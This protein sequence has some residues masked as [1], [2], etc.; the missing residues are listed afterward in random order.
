MTAHE[1]GVFVMHIVQERRGKQDEQQ[2]EIKEKK[3]PG[4]EKNISSSL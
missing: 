4:R 2:E 3:N 1:S